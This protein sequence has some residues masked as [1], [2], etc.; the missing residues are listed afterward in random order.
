[1]DEV[2]LDAPGKPLVIHLRLVV[3]EE[4]DPIGAELLRK[5]IQAHIQAQTLTTKEANEQEWFPPLP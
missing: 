5:R 2:D 3:D 4:T 1:M